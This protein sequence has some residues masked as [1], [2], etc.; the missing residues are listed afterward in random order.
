MNRKLSAESRELFFMIL[1]NSP[2]G[3]GGKSERP[4]RIPVQCIEPA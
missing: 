3:C 1:S 2:L 4:L